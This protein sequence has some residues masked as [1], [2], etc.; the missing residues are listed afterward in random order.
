MTSL[1]DHALR[2]SAKTLN[3]IVIRN[4]LMTS[5]PLALA[6]LQA[7]TS[8]YVMSGRL[9]STQGDLPQSLTT[10][11]LSTNS[12]TAVPQSVAKLSH[13]RILHL[14]SNLITSIDEFVFP[15]SL[16]NL[17]LTNNTIRLLTSLTFKDNMSHLDHLDLSNN[18]LTIIHDGAFS[19]TSSLTSLML[20]GDQL[21]RL[22]LA[23]KDLSKMTYLSVG[24]NA[25]LVC[26]CQEAGLGA[27]FHSLSHVVL[28][29]QCQGDDVR[30]FLDTLA[31]QCP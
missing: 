1:S 5:L 19:H 13:L 21:L 3:E 7:L 12:F 31:S 11:W 9:S 4:S 25:Q 29:G 15:S 30:Y 6:D 20:T 24:G 18:P 2:E 10:V 16:T 22:P 8:L 28:L 17:Y 14:G 26:T 23:L 27:W